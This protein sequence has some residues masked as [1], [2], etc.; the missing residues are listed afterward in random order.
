MV[1]VGHRSRQ[2]IQ[3]W[4]GNQLP[5]LIGEWRELPD[6]AR[7]I[8]AGTYEAALEYVEEW[9]LYESQRLDIEHYASMGLLTP[10]QERKLTELRQLVAE[11]KSTLD[12]LL[13]V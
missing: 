8:D 6:I 11:H 1:S 9:R 3:W 4:V 2:W 12:R 7:E 13:G 10:S 5:Y